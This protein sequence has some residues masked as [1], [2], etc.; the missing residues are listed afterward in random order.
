MYVR[1]RGNTTMEKTYTQKVH[2]RIILEG[3]Y[4]I[5]NLSEEELLNNSEEAHDLVWEYVA[6]N[7][8]DYYPPKITLYILRTEEEK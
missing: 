7:I 5:C 4:S 8:I 6:D 2:Y 3:D 1:K